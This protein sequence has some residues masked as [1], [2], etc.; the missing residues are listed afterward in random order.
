[1]RVRGDPIRS[2][3]VG[4]MVFHDDE[5]KDKEVGELSEDALAEVMEDE[6]EDDDLVADQSEEEK[7]WA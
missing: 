6:D 5:E 7:D 3:S 1:M 4:D 2:F